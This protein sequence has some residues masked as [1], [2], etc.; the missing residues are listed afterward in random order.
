MKISITSSSLFCHGCDQ[1]RR[2][3]WNRRINPLLCCVFHKMRYNNVSIPFSFCN[4]FPKLWPNFENDNILRNI[5]DFEKW[6]NF[7]K[8]EPSSDTCTTFWKSEHFLNYLTFIYNSLENSKL[9]TFLNCSSFFKTIKKLKT[10]TNFEVRAKI[11]KF[12]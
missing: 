1:C 12:S 3:L 9:W 11:W 6:P 4:M 2:R 8:M 7:E 10:R 5:R